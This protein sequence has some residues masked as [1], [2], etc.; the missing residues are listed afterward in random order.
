MVCALFFG[1]MVLGGTVARADFFSNAYLFCGALNAMTGIGWDA[2]REAWCS[3]KDGATITL[4]DENFS[5][6]ISAGTDFKLF[7]LNPCPEYYPD[8][9][10]S[11]SV[12]WFSVGVGC[13]PP[14]M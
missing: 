14:S 5:F 6:T 3:A 13:E 1:W 9:Q 8:C 12:L 7:N 11:L 10:F 4:G 2:C